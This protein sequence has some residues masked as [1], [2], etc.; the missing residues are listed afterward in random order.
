MS[1][2]FF[3]PLIEGVLVLWTGL[4]P[5][6]WDESQVNPLWPQKES[7]GGLNFRFL[8]RGEQ[9]VDTK[10]SIS[11]RKRNRGSNH[12]ANPSGLMSQM[13]LL[14]YWEINNT[15]KSKCLQSV[16]MGLYLTFR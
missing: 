2:I 11:E 1:Q 5:P 10:T 12:S 16:S 14:Q 7:T 15:I 3:F 6:D 4:I 9:M 13:L 8:K